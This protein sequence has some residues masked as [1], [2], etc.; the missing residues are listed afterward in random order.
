MRTSD[1]ALACTL[2]HIEYAK[3]KSYATLKR[4]DPDFIPPTSVHAQN[5]AARLGGELFSNGQ[6]RDR[7]DAMDE[8]QRKSKRE[9]TDEESDEEEMEI[10]DEDEPATS[11]QNGGMCRISTCIIIVPDVRLHCYVHPQAPSLKHLSSLQH[12]CYVQISRRRLQTMFWQCCSNSM[13]H[14]ALSLP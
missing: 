6:K 9:K 5:T 8:D 13:W 14:G 12:A 7:D 4:D 10:E 11:N 1:A 2:Q 3:T